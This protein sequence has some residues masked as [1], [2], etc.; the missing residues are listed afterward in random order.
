VRFFKLEQG[1]VVETVNGEPV[2]NAAALDR[3]FHLMPELAPD[4]ITV[5]RAINR[6]GQPTGSA[7]TSVIEIHYVSQ[8]VV[9]EIEHSLNDNVLAIAPQL[10]KVL[11]QPP[12]FR[13][14]IVGRRY[15][16]WEPGKADPDSKR[17]DAAAERILN[18]AK[19]ARHVMPESDTAFDCSKVRGTLK[20]VAFLE[21]ARTIELSYIDWI[22]AGTRSSRKMAAF[23]RDAG[24]SPVEGIDKDTALAKMVTVPP[25][26]AIDRTEVTR[27]Q[28]A[29]WLMTDPPT[30]GQP[31]WCAWNGDYT[32]RCE[33]PPGKKGNHPVV[34]IDWC[35]AFA[36]CKAVGKRLC[37]AMGGGAVAWADIDNAQKSEWYAACSAGGALPFPYGDSYESESC[38]GLDKTVT[39]CHHGSCTTAEVGAAGEC[40][41]SGSYEGV[42]DLSGNVAE[43]EDSCD[44]TTGAND[45]CRIRGGSFY[46]P[47]GG[48]RCRAEDSRHRSEGDRHI[49]FRCCS[50]R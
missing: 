10:P 34:C 43:L 40:Q 48:L 45:L 2:K 31:S 41:S 6:Y 17:L 14:I 25:G 16:S 39:G 20:R 50:D 42:Y 7:S 37:G 33:W 3:I 9:R 47:G 13:T 19:T 21:G 12:N 28:Y 15:R 24:S 32:P 35:D 36:Y 26:F 8:D 5:R 18:I 49:G 30:K 11:Q 46:A 38:N 1:D 22:D 27:Q 4:V 23:R 44:G 29:T